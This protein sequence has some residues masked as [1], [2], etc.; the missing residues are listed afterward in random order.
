MCVTYNW[1]NHKN[2]G[3]LYKKFNDVNY[4][5]MHFYITVN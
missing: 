5:K 1:S 4:L 3:F 2:T